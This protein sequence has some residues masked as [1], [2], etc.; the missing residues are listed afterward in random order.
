MPWPASQASRSWPWAASP[1]HGGVRAVQRVL[2]SARVQQPGG[3]RGDEL[4]DVEDRG[5]AAGP[6]HDVEVEVGEPP[7]V[8]VALDLADVVEVLVALVGPGSTRSR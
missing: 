1:V 8:T 2:G 7:P 3:D 6:Q 5:S 4:V